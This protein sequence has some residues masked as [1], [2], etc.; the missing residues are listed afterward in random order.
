MNRSLGSSGSGSLKNMSSN[1][2]S[3]AVSTGPRHFEH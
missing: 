1:S 2:H 3:T